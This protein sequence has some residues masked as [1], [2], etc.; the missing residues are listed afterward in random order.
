MSTITKNG[1]RYDVRD[2]WCIG[3]KC[4]AL[5]AYQHRGATG[6]G[7]RNTGAI[8]H[9]CMTRAYHGC[10]N[11]LPEY[12]LELARGRRVEGVRVGRG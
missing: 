3:R 9:C 11:S 6:K 7:S 8:S 5:G 12:D 4:L 10:P 1:V 2:V